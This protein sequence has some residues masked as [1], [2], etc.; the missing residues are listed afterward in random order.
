MSHQYSTVPGQRTVTIDGIEWIVDSMRI[1]PYCEQSSV[2]CRSRLRTITGEEVGGENNTWVVDD[3]YTGER[4]RDAWNVYDHE[5]DGH[6]FD[7]EPY[8]EERCEVCDV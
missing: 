1:Y 8:I 6:D 3:E 2:R 4:G 7:F 5:L